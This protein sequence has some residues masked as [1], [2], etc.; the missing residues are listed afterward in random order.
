L[1]GHPNFTG[2][3][4]NRNNNNNTRLHYSICE[5]LGIETPENWYSHI[6][7]PVTE[8]KDTTVLWDQGMDT[9]GYRGF[10]KHA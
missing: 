1:G 2:R 4:D 6:P 5:K 3:G 10:G 9:N 8:H 7:K